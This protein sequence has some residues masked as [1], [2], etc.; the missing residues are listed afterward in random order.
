MLPRQRGY[1]QIPSQSRIRNQD[2]ENRLI[3]NYD[4]EWD[5]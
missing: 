1:N 4:E 3:D 5:D 2:A